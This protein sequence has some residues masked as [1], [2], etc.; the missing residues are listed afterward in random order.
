MNNIIYDKILLINYDENHELITDDNTI[1]TINSFG[2]KIISKSPYLIIVTTQ[3]SLSRTN[4]HFQHIL[5]EKLKME[6]YK[7][8][9]KIDATRPKNSSSISNIFSLKPKPY[10]IRTR[11]YY[12]PEKVNF[13][14]DKLMLLGSK[15]YFI[16]K[17]T[18]MNKYNSNNIADNIIGKYD[19][20][21]NNIADNI[22][23]KY[24]FAKNN[25]KI[26]ITNYKARRYTDIKSSKEGTGKIIFVLIYIFDGKEYKLII[27]NNCNF[28]SHYGDNISNIDNIYNN[29]IN[30]NKVKI[31]YNIT[32]R[33]IENLSKYNKIMT[34]QLNDLKQN[35]LKDNRNRI[36]SKIKTLPDIIPG[37]I[38]EYYISINKNLIIRHMTL[39]K[40]IDQKSYNNKLLSLNQQ[41]LKKD[42]FNFFKNNNVSIFLNS[43]YRDKIS[44]NEIPF[45]SILIAMDNNT[46]K[47][48]FA[49]VYLNLYNDKLDKINYIL[50]FVRNET[51]NNG[52]KNYGI[53][54]KENKNKILNI[55]DTLIKSQKME[56]I[57]L[58]FNIGIQMKY[59]NNIDKIRYI[60]YIYEFGVY[61]DD[62][63]QYFYSI[64]KKYS[65][66]ESFLSKYINEPFNIKNIILSNI[67]LKL[68]H[69]IKLIHD[70]GYIHCDIKPDN[71]LIENTEKKEE[72]KNFEN[73]FDLKI[74]DFGAI[75]KINDDIEIYTPIY[76]YSCKYNIAMQYNDLHAFFI[77]FND[78]LNLLE[79][80]DKD[81]YSVHNSDNRSYEK[82][83]DI[84]KSLNYENIEYIKEYKITNP[85][86][87]TEYNTFIDKIILNIEEFK[88]KCI[89]KI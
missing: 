2:D 1:N 68:L 13:I 16:D 19:F 58:L 30:Q 60:P 64:M 63:E 37:D 49:T 52:K 27:S 21:K 61:N 73:F 26:L 14:D 71:L 79:I 67:A 29:T 76:L 89:D 22:I 38:K 57:G 50:R 88:Q 81:R 62:K 54:K 74:N 4:K 31:I 72:Y 23:D 33:N 11:I 42:S 25:D 7:V 80:T 8:F 66:V 82:F 51:N 39:F 48:S 69:S 28:D 83:Y 5:G 87:V 59:K 77:S 86:N 78:F 55:K 84:M 47:G 56:I 24:D 20:A 65:S 6:G 12:H 53:L 36:I 32:P 34:I 3:N 75:K 18:Y 70:E 10:N 15:S 41:G 46:S 35:I 9:S 45:K 43:L 85:V 44:K 17:D 40:I